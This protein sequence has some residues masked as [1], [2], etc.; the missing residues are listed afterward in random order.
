MRHVLKDTLHI[1]HMHLPTSHMLRHT[2]R[3][4]REERCSN[5]RDLASYLEGEE[6]KRDD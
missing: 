5:I 6:R 3:E 4:E 1:V 2:E